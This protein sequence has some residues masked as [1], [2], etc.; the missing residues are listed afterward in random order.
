MHSRVVSFL[1]MSLAA[2]VW[3][4][5]TLAQS[6]SRPDLPILTGIDLGA[7]LNRVVNTAGNQTNWLSTDGS[8]LLLQ[9]PGGEYT[10]SS[11]PNQ[12]Q[13][14]GPQPNFG[15][16]LIYA[17]VAAAPAQPGSR[18]GQDM[19]GYQALK[20]RMR[21][22]QVS[23]VEIAIKDSKQKDDGSETTVLI[24]VS[25]QWQTYYIPL[26]WFIKVDLSQI[27]FLT[28]IIL[29]GRSP[30]RVQVS[31]IAYTSQPPAAGRILPDFTYGGGWSS[32]MYFTNLSG[33]IVTFPV[34]FFK[35]DGSPM[36]ISTPSNGLLRVGLPVEM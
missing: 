18:G 31:E 19:R 32:T 34:S 1:A 22:D 14:S 20:L 28:E 24:T 35:D 9:Y 16:L 33:A 21:G 13:P 25:P 8:S 27:Y 2:V 6:T 10:T 23:T 11:S 12:S 17:D 30:Q 15:F 29:N 3:L 7:G 4:R 26:S 36:Y 5:P